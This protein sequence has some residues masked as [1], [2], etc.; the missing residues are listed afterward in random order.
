MGSNEGE[1]EGFGGGFG[2]EEEG[3]EDFEDDYHEGLEDKDVTEDEKQ[4]SKHDKKQLL[5]GPQ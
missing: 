5:V 1:D 2:A 3:E 4:L